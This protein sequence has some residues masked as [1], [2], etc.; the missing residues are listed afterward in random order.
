MA[1]TA[2]AVSGDVRAQAPDEPERW[3]SISIGDVQ[4]QVGF[5][6]AFPVRIRTVGGQVLDPLTACLA[7]ERLTGAPPAAVVVRANVEIDPMFAGVDEGVV[8]TLDERRELWRAAGSTLAA[9]ARLL[10]RVNNSSR[11]VLQ[12]KAET[13]EMRKALK[14]VQGRADRL[15]IERDQA[16]AALARERASKPGRVLT[17]Y[18]AEEN[19]ESSSM[20]LPEDENIADLIRDRFLTSFARKSG[21]P[22]H[23][24]MGFYLKSHG[25]MAAL[26]LFESEEPKRIKIRGAE[27][28]LRAGLPTWQRAK[29]RELLE[30]HGINARSRWHQVAGQYSAS[31]YKAVDGALAALGAPAIQVDIEELA[32]PIRSALPTPAPCGCRCKDDCDIRPGCSA[33]EGE[34]V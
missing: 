31:D 24:L 8:F 9:E 26:R 30:D 1:M 32:P 25:D 20:P 33:E 4:M 21:S 18:N 2:A 15:E 12:A 10:E 3:E 14:V 7:V 17:A 22:L 16:V 28:L 13:I 27:A 5:I 23:Q 34:G 11:R 19:P 29:A 6:A